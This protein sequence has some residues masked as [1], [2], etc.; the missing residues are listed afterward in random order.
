MTRN[1]SSS[2]Q[3]GCSHD[4]SLAEVNTVSGDTEPKSKTV[5]TDCGKFCGL[6]TGS[7]A[8]SATLS[9]VKQ[10]TSSEKETKIIFFMVRNAGIYEI[11][12]TLIFKQESFK[13]LN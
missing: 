3:E 5:R 10:N 11:L 12:N 4:F 1:H 6:C 13:G 8:F 2:F 7:C 9:Y